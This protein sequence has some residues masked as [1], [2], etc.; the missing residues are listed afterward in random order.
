MR[1]KASGLAQHGSPP[2]WPEESY[3]ADV[4]DEHM[5]DHIFKN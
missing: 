5:F 3:P 1:P 2:G 4:H